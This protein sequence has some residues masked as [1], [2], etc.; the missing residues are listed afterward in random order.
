MTLSSELSSDS[1]PK[2][3]PLATREPLAH[4]ALNGRPHLL[5]DHLLAVGELAGS[6]AARF[7]AE[8]WGRL[9]GRWHDLGKYSDSFQHRIRTE[10]GFEAHLETL[11]VKERDHSSA[12]ALR[13]LQL[14]Q[15]AVPLAFVIAGHHAGLSD[16]S[17]LLKERL[18]AKEHL[19]KEVSVRADPSILEG[20]LHTQP[21]IAAD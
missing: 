3:V 7:G 20:I 17:R 19:L 21:V 6:F 14:G 10:N 8:A 11:D 1:R 16:R 5:V 18:P 4:L 12:G 15:S 13:A 9:A 2:R